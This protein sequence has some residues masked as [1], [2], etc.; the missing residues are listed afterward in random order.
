MS[1]IL[2]EDEDE[3]EEGGKGCV[4][5]EERATEVAGCRG[6]GWAIS[7]LFA[8]LVDGLGIGVDALDARREAAWETVRLTVRWVL[9]YLN[10]SG[11]GPMLTSIVVL[12]AQRNGNGERESVL[13]RM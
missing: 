4:T 11:V 8:V 10:S 7:G 5:D 6:A 9:E 12:L 2:L 13:G 3:D 1:A